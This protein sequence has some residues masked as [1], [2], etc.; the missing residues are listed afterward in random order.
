MKGRAVGYLIVDGDARIRS[1]L[2]YTHTYATFY[3]QWEVCTHTHVYKLRYILCICLIELVALVSV[4]TVH[5]GILFSLIC[6]H[7]YIYR[8]TLFTRYST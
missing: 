2:M 8:Y 1:W 4:Y 6:E 3:V 5:V 7:R